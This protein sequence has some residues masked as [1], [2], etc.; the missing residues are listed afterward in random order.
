MPRRR[1]P[2]ERRIAAE[3]EACA[4]VADAA[5]DRYE[6]SRWSSEVVS[7]AKDIAEEIRSRNSCLV[8]AFEGVDVRQ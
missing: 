4:R 7:V 2:W 6:L 1:R 3:R 5:A 8:V